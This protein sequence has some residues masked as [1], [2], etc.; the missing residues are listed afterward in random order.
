MLC[1]AAG[2]EVNN[3]KKNRR[4]RFAKKIFRVVSFCIKIVPRYIVI[5]HNNNKKMYWVRHEFFDIFKFAAIPLIWILSPN[6]KREKIRTR[7]RKKRKKPEKVRF[8]CFLALFFSPKDASPNDP[9]AYVLAEVGAVIRQG[10]RKSK[11][12]RDRGTG[13][14]CNGPKRHAN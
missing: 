3:S 13:R 14:A 5:M 12:K 6:H 10:V 9:R 1:N 8:L 2:S 4:R 11:K 7:Q